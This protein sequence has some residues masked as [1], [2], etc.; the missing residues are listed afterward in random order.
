MNFVDLFINRS[1]NILLSFCEQFILVFTG[2]KF[3]YF[4][5]R[6]SKYFYIMIFINA[7]CH[8]GLDFQQ[9]ICTFSLL[10]LICLRTFHGVNMLFIV[11]YLLMSYHIMM[12]YGTVG[13]LGVSFPIYDLC[14]V[15]TLCFQQHDVSNK[16]IIKH[17]LP[18]LLHKRNDTLFPRNYRSESVVIS[19]LYVILYACICNFLQIYVLSFIAFV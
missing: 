17:H 2:Y 5:L 18:T 7:K 19:K 15:V 16:D 1:H 9:C 13:S 12:M 8:F 3:T 14:L 10:T 4:R 6:Y 11:K